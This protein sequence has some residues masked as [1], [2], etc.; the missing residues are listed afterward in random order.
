MAIV[1]PLRSRMYPSK[2]REVRLN[3]VAVPVADRMAFLALI[4]WPA[5]AGDDIACGRRH[6]K[7]GSGYRT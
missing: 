3:A 2:Q 4:F 5:G 1:A 7:S 6:G